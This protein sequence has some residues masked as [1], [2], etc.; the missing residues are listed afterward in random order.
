MSYCVYFQAHVVKEHCWYLTAILRSYEHVAFDRTID[1]ATSRFEFF[2]AP[3]LE[4]VF[5]KLMNFFVERGI[6]TGLQKLP[7]RLAHT[8]TE[9]Q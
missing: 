3:H 8:S 9:V 2:V 1:V 6:V 7:N 4:D 5:L